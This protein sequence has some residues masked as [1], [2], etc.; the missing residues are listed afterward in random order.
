MATE[1]RLC[2]K[3]NMA[4]THA[5]FALGELRDSLAIPLLESLAVVKSEKI[6]APAIEALGKIGDKSTAPFVRSILSDYFPQKVSQA[7]LAL[8]RLGD[9]ASVAQ[10][11]ELINRNDPQ[12]LYY[13]T[14]ALFRLAPDSAFAFFDTV[15]ARSNDDYI[16]SI[17]VRGLGSS[18]DTTT[19]LR[20]FQKR[21]K[22]SGLNA[23]IEFI[24]ALGREKTGGGELE[25]I[26]ATES[27]SALKNEIIT[28]LG[29]IGSKSSFTTVKKYIIDSSLQVRLAAIAALP[30]LD[31]VQSYSILEKLSSDS[32]WQI[33]AAAARSLGKTNLPDAEKLLKAM[34]ADK[35]NRVRPA[36][37]EGLSEFPLRNNIEVFDNALLNDSD[38][39][40]RATAA[41][42]LGSA[43]SDSA[44]MLLIQ[45]ASHNDTSSDVDLCRSLVGALGNYADSSL[46]G[47][48][49]LTA[50]FPYLRHSN[51]IVRQDAAAAMKDFTPK[52]FEIGE[53]DTLHLQDYQNIIS[54]YSGKI[55]KAIIYTN[56]G[57]IVVVL[58]KADSPLTSANFIYLAKQGFYDGLTFHR[59]V[60]DFVIQGGDPRGDGSGGPGYMIRE[61]INGPQI[62]NHFTRG[63]IG[64]ATSGR[65]TGGSQFFICLSPQPH[66]DGRYSSFG[67]VTDGFEVLDK[68]EIGDKIDSVR[69]TTFELVKL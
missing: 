66:L 15:L 28:A 53:F 22:D 68:I 10:I 2:L 8:W 52:N 13:A 7:A 19:V 39:I 4:N 14:Y 47:Q 32:R 61:E 11:K 51:R 44:L 6:A 12:I 63:T 50:L 21:Y 3:A 29:A 23:R 25:L 46:K 43:K 57:T 5:I 18:K 1:L 59:V 67:L 48:A 9:T 58:H 33:R 37:L 36:V 60:P 16:R 49:A 65:D 17:A 55:A 26:L 24:R 56:R 41:D 31:K 42:I 54:E 45:A 62:F 38:P 64:M 27:N 20:A 34:M 30:Q 40:T 35:D 69:V